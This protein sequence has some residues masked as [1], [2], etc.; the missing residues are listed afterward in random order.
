MP[1]IICF[2]CLYNLGFVYGF[3]AFIGI[4]SLL[5]CTGIDAKAQEVEKILNELGEKK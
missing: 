3:L 2:I 5:T 1:F 4:M